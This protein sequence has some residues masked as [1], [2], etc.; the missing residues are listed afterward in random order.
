MDRKPLDVETLWKMP[1]VGAPVPSPDGTRAIVPVTTYDMETNEGTTR[2]WEL[3]ADATG[4]GPGAPAHALTTADASSGQPAWS[5][6]GRRLAFTRKPGGDA[7]DGKR[8]KGPAH[9]DAPQ[10][11][12]MPTDG[13][14][15][16]RVT[17][18]PFGVA[19]PR[20]F[21]DGRRVGFRSMVY[22]DAPTLEE[23]AKRKKA[24][25]DEPM[26]ARISEDRFCRYW[27]RWLTDGRFFHLFVL[28]L[29]TRELQ[30]LTPD[31][32]QMVPVD[33]VEAFAIAPDG[34]EI[35]F[36][37][38]RGEPPYDL[39]IDTI[40]TMRVPAR[41][42]RDGKPPKLR[43][44]TPGHPADSARPVYSPDG[45]WIVWGMRREVDFYADRVRLVAY[46]RET[47]QR[48][49]LTEDW[50]SS[51]HAWAF[52]E[53]SKTLLLLSEVDARVAL[54]RLNL[55][56]AVKNPKRNRPREIVRG[57]T[58]AGLRLA[59]G[60]VF[61]SLSS[62]R[63]P[64][65]ACVV[66]PRRGEV[67]RLSA[68]TSEVMK[69]VE[70][71]RVEDL[72]FVGA[73]DDEVQMFLLLPPGERMPKKGAKLRRR[74][75]L[76]HMI[77]GGPHGTFGDVW[78]W[79]WNAQAFAAPGH[80]VACVNFHGSTSFGEAFT[81]SIL[82]RWGDQ[83][84]EDVMAATD[85]LLKLGLVNRNRMAVTGGSYGGYL[86][87]WIASQTDRFACA[88]NHAGVSDFQTQYA[89]DITQGRARSMGGEPWDRLEDM[90]RYNPMRHARGFRT[91]MLVLHGEQDFRVGIEVY[92]VYK[93]MKL[94]ARLVVYP[95]ENHWILKP[96]NSRHWYGEVLGWLV[97]WMR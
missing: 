86:V 55:P 87:S 39:L 61:S 74:W 19:E 88:V 59:D 84:Y 13:G 24:L 46:R 16:E 56:A 31:L 57:G 18:L 73:E 40:Y 97:R 15:P 63:E 47:K 76:V 94:P 51:P 85:H 30:D 75:P 89:S 79:R 27:D 14:E 90:D 35:A 82:G 25:A 52:A 21:P 10:L 71:S 83:P 20:W 68:F 53:D 69:G 26:K 6:D 11:F 43:E 22:R 81:S 58:F 1:R 17:D 23:T 3:P 7:G 64:P 2:L 48:T 12:V 29:E 4:A 66:D 54:W 96:R 65:E 32:W 80:A 93:A 28:D 36:T 34:R 37:C 78:H 44:V 92:A 67:R 38:L 95:D 91:P 45:A 41:V 33:Q 49:V 8:K 60:R 42:R 9:P 50:D 70:I 62:L 77:H 72:R 5:P